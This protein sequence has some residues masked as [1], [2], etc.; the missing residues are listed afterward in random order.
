LFAG[1]STSWVAGH[2]D[3][4]LGVI[5]VSLPP[6]PEQILEIKRQIPHELVHILLFEKLG[7]RYSA[8]PRWLNEGLATVAELFPNPDYQLLLEKAYEREGLI[9]ILDLC[10]SFPI[11][12]A[13][14]QLSYA[15]SYAFTWY[16]LQTYGNDKIEGLIQAYANGQACDQGIHTVYGESLTNLEAAWRLARFNENLFFNTWIESLPLIIVFGFVFLVPIGLIILKLG[17]RGKAP[18][19]RVLK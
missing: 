9:P 13:N 11:D 1:S 3:P 6:G 8:M 2:A 10:S 5:M 17:K 19:G 4:D 18:I 7:S 15:E 14:F 16:L 12:A